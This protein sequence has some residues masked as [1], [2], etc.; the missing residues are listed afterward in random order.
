MTEM[1][2]HGE[3]LFAI[4]TMKNVCLKA[5]GDEWSVAYDDGPEDKST[6]G[7]Q[8][9]DG[10]LVTGDGEGTMTEGDAKFIALMDPLMAEAVIGLL[11][12]AR[13]GFASWQTQKRALHIARHV[14]KKYP[15]GG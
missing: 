4:R 10:V 6:V 13:D 14:N 3:L 11:E 12:E 15:E 8:A 5:Y 1:S 9:E 7:V 2:P